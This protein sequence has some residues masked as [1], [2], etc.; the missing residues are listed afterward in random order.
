[1][2]VRK[3]LLPILVM[4]AVLG[5]AIFA[6]VKASSAQSALSDMCGSGTGTTGTCCASSPSPPYL[7]V[8]DRL[9]GAAGTSACDVWAVGLQPTSS[10]IMHWDG[11]AWAVSFNRPVGYFFGVSATSTSDAWAVGGTNWF[12]PSQTLAEHWD[13]TSWSQVA[14][15]AEP[16]AFFRA[17][18]ATSTTNAWAVGLI[19]PGPG[20]QSSATEP[21][22]E[23]WNGSTWSVQ[24][25]SVPA[26]GGA[27]QAVTATSSTDAWAVGWSGNSQATLIYHW[28]GSTWTRVSSP[29]QAGTYNILSGVTA[30]ASNDAWAVGQTGTSSGPDEPLIM[31]WNGSTWT[32]ATGVP[33]PAGDTNLNA[34]S[35]DSANDVW[36]TGYSNPTTCGHG[37]SSPKCQ[38]VVLHWGGTAWTVVS[39]PNPSSTYLNDYAGVVA[40]AS[41][42]VWMVGTTDYASTLIAHWNGR[43]CN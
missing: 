41:D 28:D 7:S 24:P 38:G 19:G 30:I 21:L 29:N 1:M 15:P 39:C 6:G 9:Y 26:D 8:R 22:I 35:G 42:D 17:V 36:A 37:G 14:T 11:S 18:A 5:V 34:V 10:L 43:T 25:I 4:P 3:N 2:I 33:D 40:L 12:N 32:V 16:S 27:L 20:V 23:R 31:R 13:G